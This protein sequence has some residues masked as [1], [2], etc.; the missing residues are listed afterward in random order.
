YALQF[1][2]QVH[3]IPTVLNTEVFQPSQKLPS[4]KL[5]IGWSGLE[6]NFKYLQPLVPVLER[7]Q[8]N[9]PVELVILSGSPPGL[10]IPFRFEKWNKSSEAEQL[11]TFDIGIMPLEMDEWC[12]GKCGFK[13]LQYMSLEIPSVATPV[14]VNSEIVIEGENGFT[15]ISAAD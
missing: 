14:G 9:Y 8:K 6:Y 5:R 4:D 13:L 12:R 11:N 15:A 3:V 10:S 1:Q 2:S 7:L